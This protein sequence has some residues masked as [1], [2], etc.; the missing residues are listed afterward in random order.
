MVS[1]CS[2]NHIFHLS[3]SPLHIFV[4]RLARELPSPYIHGR[5][6]RGDAELSTVA[7]SVQ[8]ENENKTQFFNSIL[9]CCSKYS[10]K[11]KDG[12]EQTPA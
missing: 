9:L 4:A 10:F 3:A 11:A 6:N 2:N 12:G 8:F 1:F 5:A 7:P